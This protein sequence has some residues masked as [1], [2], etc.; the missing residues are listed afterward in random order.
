[1]Q[2]Q[3]SSILGYP[4]EYASDSSSGIGYS[5]S[6]AGEYRVDRNVFVG[7][8]FGLDNAQDYR[9]WNGGL[10]LRYMLEDITA[11]MPLPV[12]PY[13]SPYSQ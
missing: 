9:Q 4:A 13:K 2:A 10:Y 5:F 1:M 8:H 6:G 3:A 7:G 12:S 11:P